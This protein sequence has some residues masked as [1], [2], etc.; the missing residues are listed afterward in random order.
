MVGNVVY[1]SEEKELKGKTM[2]KQNQSELE[3]LQVLAENESDVAAGRVD[4]IEDTF[5]D[6]HVLLTEE[7][8]G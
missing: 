1:E 3:L 7:K 5:R 4:S 2:E 6:L 8:D